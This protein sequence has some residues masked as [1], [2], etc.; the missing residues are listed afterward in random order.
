MHKIS[1]R[2]S[3]YLDLV[4]ALAAFAVVL[5]HAPIVLDARPVDG[6][7]QAALAPGTQLYRRPRG[8][9]LAGEEVIVFPEIIF[10]RA[11][12]NDGLRKR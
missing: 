6:G 5:D 2:E 8:D 12:K 11:P 9:N 3:L 4:R 10:E 7:Q 1:L